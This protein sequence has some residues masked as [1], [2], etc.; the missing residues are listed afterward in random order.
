MVYH[1]SMFYLVKNE[2]SYQCFGGSVHG[3]VC[4]YNKCALIKIALEVCN[5]G[6]I[7][8]TNFTVPKICFISYKVK[9]ISATNSKS[10]AE[11]AHLLHRFPVQIILQSFS[12]P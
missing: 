7:L 4:F 12:H 5:G 1:L 6:A 11:I 8:P 2:A 3:L 10:V 9:H